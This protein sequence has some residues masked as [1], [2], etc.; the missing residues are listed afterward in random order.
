M[1]VINIQCNYGAGIIAVLKKGS[2]GQVVHLVDNMKLDC[3]EKIP[4]ADVYIVLPIKKL[5]GKSF[6]LETI[7]N[8]SATVYLVEYNWK[9]NE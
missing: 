1:N 9:W 4:E 3:G 8:K 2:S 7:P 5:Q 6:G